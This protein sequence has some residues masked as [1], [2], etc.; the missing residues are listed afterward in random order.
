MFNEVYRNAVIFRRDV[1]KC[2]TRNVPRSARSSVIVAN[3]IKLG[4]VSS[5][6]ITKITRFDGAIINTRGEGRVTL[7]SLNRVKV[8]DENVTNY[9]FKM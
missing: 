7:N 5:V 2:N 8:F 6:I 3:D 9:V 4:L 1:I